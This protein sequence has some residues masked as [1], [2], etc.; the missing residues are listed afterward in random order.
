L[1]FYIFQFL[2]D[3][4]EIFN[5]VISSFNIR[6][7]ET[8][9]TGE[10]ES[11]GLSTQKSFRTPQKI[12]AKNPKNSEKIQKIQKIRTKKSPK[13]TKKRKNPIFFTKKVQ[14]ISKKSKNL[15]KIRKIPENP[16]FFQFSD[17]NL[18]TP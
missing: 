2:T 1:A 11:E 3:W 17:L 12:Y 4:T 7:A 9:H 18:R 10:A 13:S 6:F 5:Y 16:D 14:I 15:E 8:E